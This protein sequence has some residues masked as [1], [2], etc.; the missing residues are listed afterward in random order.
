MFGFLKKDNTGFLPYAEVKSI[1]EA[2]EVAMNN[3]IKCHEL[4]T[5]EDGEETWQAPP[6]TIC[7]TQPYR[8]NFIHK[9]SQYGKEFY[10]KYAKDILQGTPSNF[11]YDYHT[12][13]F[14]YRM[15]FYDE[16][17]NTFVPD[18]TYNKILNVYI[19]QIEYVVDKLKSEPTTRRALA[20]TWQP[21]I[22]EVK[23]DVPCL[24]FIQFW[25]ENGYLNMYVVFRSEDILSAMNPNMYGI[26]NIQ[27]HVATK[28]GV[29]IGK[30][31]HTITMP[32]AYW[33][34]DANVLKNWL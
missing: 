4:V 32:H 29:K 17:I 5:T 25:I 31:Y 2:Y 21:F 1:S 33:Q 27:K 9:F 3:V 18:E 15:H 34:R 7:I 12:R 13:I 14:K 16:L 11:V 10:A 30:Y 24:Q 8:S 28:V 23:K 26:Y 6:F 22:D 20:I 19:D